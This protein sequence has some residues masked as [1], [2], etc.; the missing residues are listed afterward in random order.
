MICMTYVCEQA[1]SSMKN[2]KSSSRNRLL[3]SNLKK[4]MIAA[5]T[6]YTPNFTSFAGNEQF[7]TRNIIGLDSVQT[8][9]PV[10]VL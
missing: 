7:H 2:I 10:I 5:T 9:F 1:F 3:D 6:Q 8:E 4:L